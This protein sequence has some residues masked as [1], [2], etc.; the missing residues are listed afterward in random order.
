MVEKSLDDVPSDKATDEQK[1]EIKKAI[2]SLR[3]EIKN[4][5]LDKI[6]DR[7]KEVEKLWNPI[8]E[9]MYKS[10]QTDGANAQQG[11]NPFSGFTDAFTNNPFAK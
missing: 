10:S 5:D 9:E 4:G 7:Q 3:E 2:E 8:A 1:E 11:S 6:E